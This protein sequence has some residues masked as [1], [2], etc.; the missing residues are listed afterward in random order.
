M[1]LTEKSYI[2]CRFY[3]EEEKNFE[4]RNTL[5]DVFFSLVLEPGIVHLEAWKNFVRLAKNKEHL[6]NQKHFHKENIQA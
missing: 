3:Q 2:T 1:L 6:Q 4:K 5:P